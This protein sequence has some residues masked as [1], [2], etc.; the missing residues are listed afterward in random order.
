MRSLQSTIRNEAHSKSLIVCSLL[1]AAAEKL[2]RELDRQLKGNSSRG[3]VRRTDA[4]DG[5]MSRDSGIM[6]Q[7]AMG[8]EVKKIVCIHARILV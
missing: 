6:S 4:M 1:A 3:I 7:A 8:E 5:S 2:A